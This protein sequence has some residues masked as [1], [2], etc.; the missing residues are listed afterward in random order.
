MSRSKSRYRSRSMS[1]KRNYKKR[2]VKFKSMLN[3]C[4]EIKA[5]PANKSTTFMFTINSTN[6]ASYLTSK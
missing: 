3:K 1:V 6:P 2:I 4:S 5:I